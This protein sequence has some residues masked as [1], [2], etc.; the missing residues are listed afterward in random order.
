MSIH[1]PVCK[2]RFPLY[3]L[4]SRFPCTHCGNPLA[5]QLAAPSLTFLFLFLIVN[6]FIALVWWMLSQPDPATTA[7]APATQGEWDRYPM[8]LIILDCF[9]SW[10]LFVWIFNTITHIG[11]D[12]TQ[13]PDGRPH[14]R[15]S[16]RHYHA[17]EASAK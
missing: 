1:C 14:H 8:F 12:L 10:G 4:R 5:A 15:T 2:H 3:S 17:K 16:T 9:L 6:G 11:L 13:L 7:V